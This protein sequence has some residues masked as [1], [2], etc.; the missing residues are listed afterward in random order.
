MAVLGAGTMK[1]EAACLGRPMVLLAAAE[2]QLPVGEEFGSTGAARWLGDGRL[3]DPG[4][5]RTEVEGLLADPTALAA[6]GARARAMV[7][8]RGAERIADV[9]ET[10]VRAPR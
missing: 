6:L 8:G 9:V 4:T 2:D 10:L 7:D 1:F 5:F 3:V